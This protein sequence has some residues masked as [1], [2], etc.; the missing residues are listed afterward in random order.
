MNRRC[1]VFL[2]EKIESREYDNVDVYSGL[3]TSNNDV[4][5]TPE[6]PIAD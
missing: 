2:I 6:I 5:V 3:S 4:V 1:L